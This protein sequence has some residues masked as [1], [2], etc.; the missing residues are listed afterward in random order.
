M[1]QKTSLEIECF[2][3][4]CSNLLQPKAIRCKSQDGRDCFNISLEPCKHCALKARR[5]I[6]K[7]VARLQRRHSKRI[8]ITPQPQPQDQEAIMADHA[9]SGKFGD[10]ASGDQSKSA[11]PRG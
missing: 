5:K 3:S 10:V 4:V 6:K 9:E 7:V 8:K 1:T 11:K 2:C